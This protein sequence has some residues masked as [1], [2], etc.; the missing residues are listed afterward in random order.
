MYI[1][2]RCVRNVIIS[3]KLNGFF[4]EQSIKTLLILLASDIPYYFIKNKK[5]GT[6]MEN[7]TKI[8]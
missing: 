7:D 3:P 5:F 1:N 6:K 2:S 4:Q 8:T